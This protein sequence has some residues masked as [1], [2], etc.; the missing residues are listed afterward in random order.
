[1]QMCVRVL[2]E[3]H[4]EEF[5]ICKEERTMILMMNNLIFY[6]PSFLVSFNFFNITYTFLSSKVKIVAKQVVYRFADR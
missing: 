4:F 6:S 2:A 3:C 1:M 5:Q